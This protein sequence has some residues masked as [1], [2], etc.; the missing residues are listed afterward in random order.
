MG[1]GYNKKC[2]PKIYV[3][4]FDPLVKLGVFDFKSQNTTTTIRQ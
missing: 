4:H 3:T 2:R 1:F